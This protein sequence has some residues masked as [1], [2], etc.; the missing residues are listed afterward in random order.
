M[1]KII[2]LVSALLMIFCTFCSCSAFTKGNEETANN[3][4]PKDSIR[5]K[6]YSVGNVIDEGKQ[7]IFFR[8]ASD[9]SV[10][11]IEATGTLLDD[12]GKTIHTFEYSSGIGSPSKTPEIFIR[13]EADIAKKVRSVS[14]TN[15]KAYTS[16]NV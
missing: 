4:I 2:L 15:L 3:L 8:F 16:E 7:A 11:K 14:I 10:S 9:Y 13:V 1:K 5:F 6:N 12:S